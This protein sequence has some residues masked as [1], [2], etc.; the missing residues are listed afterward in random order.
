MAYVNR[1]VGAGPVSLKPK[2]KC[3]VTGIHK[4][5]LPQFIS[6][7]PSLVSNRASLEKKAPSRQ[8]LLSVEAEVHPYSYL[9]KTNYPSTLYLILM[10]ILSNSK[11]T[12]KIK[13]QMIQ[14][15]KI[16]TINGLHRSIERCS[17]P[18]GLTPSS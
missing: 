14:T 11:L 10:V 3:L 16:Q 7:S 9:Y 15:L 17:N 6:C 2:Y 4:K 13:P 5:C 1:S 12:E 18:R 8:K